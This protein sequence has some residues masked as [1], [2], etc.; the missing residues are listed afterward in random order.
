MELCFS[1]GFDWFWSCG[2]WCGFG[3]LSIWFWAACLWCCLTVYNLMVAGVVFVGFGQWCFWR[4]WLLILR[5]GL[6]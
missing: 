3:G 5:L 1:G 2:F 6:G 4:G